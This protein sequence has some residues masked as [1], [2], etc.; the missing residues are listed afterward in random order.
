MYGTVAL[1]IVI[2][3][4]CLASVGVGGHEWVI[5]ISHIIVEIESCLLFNQ[6]YYQPNIP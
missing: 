5:H 6:K 3:C 2:R 1:A 4:I